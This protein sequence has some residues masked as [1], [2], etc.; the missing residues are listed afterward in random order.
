MT[1]GALSAD[2][3]VRIE[4]GREGST[5]FLKDVLPVINKVGCTQG[6]CHG[7]AKGKNGFKLSLRGYDPRFDYQ[8]LLYDMSG[9]RFNRADPAQ[10]LML[11][12]PTQEVAHGGGLRLKRDSRYYDTLLKWISDGVPYGEDSTD[13]VRRL[14]VL[15]EEVFLTA[16]GQRQSVVVLAEYEDGSRRDVTRE[17]H[18]GSSNTEAIAVTEP[19]VVQGERVGEGALLVRYEGQFVTVPVT[20]LNPSSV[21]SGVRCRSTTTSTGWWTGSWNES[22]CSLR[23]PRPTAI[24]CAVSLWI[25][26]AVFP[27]P[28]KCGPSWRIRPTGRRSA[29]GP[30]I[31]SWEVTPMSI[32][33][34]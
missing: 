25:S 12:K 28:A 18:L 16:P 17:A 31:G 10:S 7:A 8:S 29:P 30:S 15:P 34:P 9:R 1:A 11:A 24:S 26:R 21:S 23:L 3:P 2:L 20:V 27:V 14:E 32:T 19:A 5:T 33:G 6:I 13:R 4:P 22:G